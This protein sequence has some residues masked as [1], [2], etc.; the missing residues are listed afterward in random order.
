MSITDTHRQIRAARPHPSLLQQHHH[1]TSHPPQNTKFL[2]L[3][4]FYRTTKSIAINHPAPAA[5]MVT[6]YHPFLL[7]A[8][9]LL[10]LTLF[11]FIVSIAW[12]LSRERQAAREGNPIRPRCER[13]C[14]FP[15]DWELQTLEMQDSLRRERA[16]RGLAGGTSVGEG[17][18]RDLEAGTGL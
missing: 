11:G 2:S 7:T 8:H 1:S 3:N 15:R 13:P 16:G 9:L 6:P 4:S 10:I 17:C 5:Q 18:S 14:R 12:T